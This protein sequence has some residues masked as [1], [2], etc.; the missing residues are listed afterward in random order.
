MVL[1]GVLAGKRRSFSFLLTGY[2]ASFR[3]AA[4][5]RSF[6][7]SQSNGISIFGMGIV[8]ASTKYDMLRIA[9]AGLAAGYFLRYHAKMSS[10]E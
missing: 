6:A 2:I 5:M 9:N 1:S 7:F 4:R 10:M 3:T 8:S